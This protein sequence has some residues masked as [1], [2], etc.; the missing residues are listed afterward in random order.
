MAGVVICPGFGQRGIEGKIVAAEY[1]RTQDI[2]TFG[3]CL[4]MQMMVIEFARNVLGFQ[5]A[6]SSE[7]DAETTHP[8]IDLMEEQKN[9][10]LMGGTMRLG[11]Y[12]C[13]LVSGS[14]TWQAYGEQTLISERH[15]HRYE[16]N[17]IFQDELEE[18]GMNCVGINPEA[19]LVEIVE[20]P[21]LRWYIGTQF[22]PEYSSTVLSPHPLFISFIKSCTKTS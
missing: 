18:N 5:D 11:A 12:N 21:A 20:I 4:G 16:L 14:K 13:E 8:V 9:V 2:P 15:R 17:N 3:I 1:C 22:H 7:M 6:N 10:K 19:N